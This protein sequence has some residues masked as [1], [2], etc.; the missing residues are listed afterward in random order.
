MIFST[1]SKRRQS[2]FDMTPM[3]DVVLQLIIFFLYTAHFSSLTRAPVDL[4][5]EKGEEKVEVGAG[6]IVIDIKGDGQLMMEREPVTLEDI[7]AMVRV[8]IERAGGASGVEV[9]VR[10]DRNVSASAINEV[11]RRLGQLGVRNWRLGT[12]DQGG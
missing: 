1:R 3:I 4:P 8:E 7:E 5:K 6:A 2:A 12:A 11:A 9:L 10:S